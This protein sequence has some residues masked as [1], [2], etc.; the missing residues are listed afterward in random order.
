MTRHPDPYRKGGPHDDVARNIR[1]EMMADGMTSPGEAKAEYRRMLAE[2]GCEVCGET[3][4]DRLG[5]VNPH[6]VACPTMGRRGGSPEQA[7][8]CTEHVR[9][10]K[11]FWWA[12]RVKNA[13]DRDSEAIVVYD[14]GLVHY[15]TLPEFP[16][17]R[18][19]DPRVESWQDIPP[20]GR[21]VP[22]APIHCRCG[23]EIDEVRYLGETA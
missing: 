10:P 7:V 17:G 20:E 12:Q 23:A 6:V 9:S 22:K 4:P 14:C 15:A 8:Y 16:E 21:P 18:F 5:L 13:R 19:N 2:K 3:D 11:E 1:N